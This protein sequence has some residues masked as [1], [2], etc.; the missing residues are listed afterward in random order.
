MRAIVYKEYGGPD[1]LHME[2]IEKPK[3][4][5][6]EVLISVRAVEA[7]KA[8]CEMRSFKFAVSWFWLPLCIALGIRKPRNPIL[9]NYFAGVIEATG[10]DVSKFQKGQNVFGGAGLRMGAYAEY[11]CV[12]DSCTMVTM[13][14]NLSFA[15]A[16]SVPLGGL[17]ALHYM[18]KAEI[19]PGDK[20]LVNGAGA[21][22]GTFAVQIAKAMG[23]EVTAVDSGIKEAM[24]RDI[25]ADHFVDYAK[26]D[27][28]KSG[29]TYDVIFSMVAQT[30][31]SSCIRA[32]KPNGRYVMANPKLSDMLRSPLT[33]R[34]SDRKVM[35]AFAGEKEEEL[36]ELKR[37]IEADEIAA[38]VDKIYSMEEAAEAHRRVETEQRLGTVVV[39]MTG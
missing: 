16:A 2:D 39:S 24:L 20:V 33:S 5:K 6:N 4:A 3:P 14:S 18:R 37:M 34:F 17:N 36:L 11:F 22:I 12:S 1:V 31:Y 35:F 13:P 27:F 26:E 21:S 30:S 23:A 10:D 7:T 29:S 38:T 19:R 28:T 32:L 15:E 9:G 25:G 8:D